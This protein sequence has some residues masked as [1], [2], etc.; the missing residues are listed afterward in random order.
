MCDIIKIQK[1]RCVVFTVLRTIKT[2]P[3]FPV[4]Y[5]WL[6]KLTSDQRAGSTASPLRHSF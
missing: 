4:R 6:N 2:G 5:T 3:H 1:V